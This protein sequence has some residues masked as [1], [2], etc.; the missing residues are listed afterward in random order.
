MAEIY[1]KEWQLA[2][3]RESVAIWNM[4]RKEQPETKIDLDETDL[5]GAQLFGVDL[6]KAQLS[7]ANLWRANLSQADLSQADLSQADLSEAHLGGAHLG[8][9]DLSQ[10][11]MRRARLIGAKL[12]GANLYRVYL[13]EADLG[14][15]DLTQA[16]LIA[17]NLS[18]ANLYR[19]NLN[20]ADLSGANLSEADLSGANLSEVTLIAANLSETN[21]RET[22]LSR[23]NLNGADLTMTNCIRTDFE[24]AT[25]TGCRIYGISSWDIRSDGAIQQ[26]LCITPDGQAQ[27]TVDNLKVAQ[28][29]YLLLTNA[30]I[31]NVIDTISKKVVL[32]LGR[33]TP[34]RKAVLDA[35]RDELRARNY[36]PVVFDFEKPA[37]RDLTETIST[38]AHLSR[39]V[40]ADLTEAK[41]IPQ[42]LS[43]IVP[44]LPSLAVQPLVQEGDTGYAMFEH[45]RRYPWV[46]NTYHYAN[47]ESLLA[48]L[49]EC[50]IDPPEAKAQEL[51]AGQQSAI[52]P[53]VVAPTLDMSRS[54]PNP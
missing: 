28:F 33:F 29:I 1:D 49:K 32:I 20:G 42:E 45:W 19:A 14:M 41:S 31:R 17:A 35:L 47:L 46:L 12:S 36:S 7:R 54:E 53:A 48:N 22:D 26:D 23:A 51:L 21:M 37:S 34:E 10:A 5:S 16:H 13:S 50:V 30:E 52:Q 43:V 25:L 9:A 24:G 11:R 4:W 6:S 38:L 40:I 8:E 44:N 15:A 2:T 18:G 3:L 39:F 27:V